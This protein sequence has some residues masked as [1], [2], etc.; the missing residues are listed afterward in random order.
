MPGIDAFTSLCLHCDGSDGATSF[1]D[2]SPHGH[3]VTP[4]G[5]AQVDTAQSV[6]GGASALFDGAGDGLVVTGH[7]SLALGSGDF[8]VDCRFRNTFATKV[9][10]DWGSF[11]DGLYVRSG[12]NRVLWRSNNSDVITS[13]V[14]LSNDTW[15]HV[16][17]VRSSGTTR[18]FIDGVQT[19]SDFSDSRDYPLPG[20]L[21]IGMREDAQFSLAGHIDE[22]RISKGTDRGWASGFTPPTVA[23]SGAAA[24]SYAAIMG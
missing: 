21:T 7:S 2:A 11:V 19:G 14:L 23:Y 8:V 5:S 10:L 1:P 4:A 22:L 6:F 17:V 13:T 15:Y 20:N 12:T 18:L 16:A 24:R 3:T 9:L